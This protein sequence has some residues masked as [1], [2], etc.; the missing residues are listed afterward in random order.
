M[1]KTV[2]IAGAT[3]YLGRFLVAEYIQRGWKVHAIVRNKGKIVQDENDTLNNKKQANLKLIQAQVTDPES[4]KDVMRIPTSA[5]TDDELEATATA[6][7]NN[8]S[9]VDLV[10]SSV[11]ITRQRDG[12]TYQQVDYQANMN[13]LQEAIQS[14]VPHFAYIHVLKGETMA[15]LPAIRAKQD[16]VEELQLASNNG[17]IQKHT[18]ICP[19][20]FFSDMKDFLDM[21][22]NGRAYLFGDGQHT[23]N[24]IH[25]KDLAKATAV[26]IEQGKNQ[27]DIGGPDVFTQ[28]QLATLAF[29]ALGPNKAPQ[30]TCLWDRLR[31]LLISILPWI[32]PVTIYGP[33]QFFLFAMG[34]DMVGEC[35]G[36]CHLQDYFA[37]VVREEQTK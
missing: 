1:T 27:V 13:L 37:E 14:K 28:T 21:A 11:G 22:K 10:I 8:G 34:Q 9:V 23:I 7:N 2:M 24:P 12:L 33:A 29:E 19:C 5:T 31:T 32:T 15:H 4:L 36:E 6:G 17:S 16:F 35:H 30:I 20:G 3:G 25:G 18:V 26:A